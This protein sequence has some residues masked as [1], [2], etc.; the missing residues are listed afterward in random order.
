MPRLAP[1]R[2]LDPSEL[3]VFPKGWTPAE[4]AIDRP[5]RD[6]TA[7]ALYLTVSCNADADEKPWWCS[8][9]YGG[10]V[11]TAWTS[12]GH[13]SAAVA[14]RRCVTQA[15]RMLRET[16]DAVQRADGR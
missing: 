6:F 14:R 5:G 10:D 8:I 15:L 13:E 1:E 9:F 11:D 4:F 16:K 7:G 12:G 3:D 2:L